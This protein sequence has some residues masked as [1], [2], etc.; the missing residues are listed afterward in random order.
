MT[1][2]MGAGLP[3][4][5]DERLL[6]GRGR[7]LDDLNPAGCLHA[8]F[9]RSPHAKARIRSLDVGPARRDEGVFAF[10]A[11]DLGPLAKPLP[12][13]FPHPSLIAPRLPLPLAKEFV[14][15]VGEPVAVVVAAD[16]Y[17]AEDAAERVRVAYEPLPAVADLEAARRGAARVHEDVADNVAA[18]GERAY[19]DLAAAFRAARH[20]VHM[21]LRIDRGTAASLE[22]RGVL[23]LPTPDGGL[24]V[25]D[26]TQAPQPT[27]QGLARFLELPEEAVR[28]RVPD[29]GGG[30][31]PKSALFYPEEVLVPYLARLL[32][33]P[34]KWVEDR[35]ENFVATNQEREQ[36]HVVR[37]AFDAEGHILGLE[38]EFWHDGGAYAQAGAIL[39]I[40]TAT[41]LMGPYRIPALRAH[42]RVLYTNRTPVSPLRGAGRPQAVFVMERVLA[43]AAADLGLDLQ[44]VRR[45]NFIRP[46]EMPYAV[47]MRYQDE[48][49]L[50]YDSG[51]YEALFDEALAAL[52]YDAWRQEQ[53]RAR[54][55]GRCIGIGVAPYVE[56]SGLGPYE[57]ATLRVDAT[58]AITVQA[59]VASQGQG[60]ETMLALVAG[61][62]LGVDP[63][64]IS[65]RLGDAA[66]FPFGMGTYGSRT[67]V[68]AGSACERAARAL[69]Q[70]ALRYGAALLGRSEEELDLDDA[71]VFC[72]SEPERRVD[73][74][75]LAAE[76][77][78]TWGPLS[79]DFT[80]GLSATAFFVPERATF[81]AGVH[82]AAVEVDPETCR[83]RILRYVVVH[84]AGNLIAPPLVE[85]QIRGGVAHGIGT[86]LYER[87]VFDEGG[88]PLAT[89]FMDYL[90]PTATEVPR[91]EVHHHP[92]PSPLNPLGAKGVGEAGVIPVPACLAEAIEDA[93][94]PFGVRIEAM[95]LSADDL[96]RILYV[97]TTQDG[98][99]V[100]GEGEL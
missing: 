78:P 85:G 46:E 6:L 77:E 2:G 61:R 72:R 30:F 75:R 31:G 5:E 99:E 17:L 40:I 7:F 80:P 87:L 88:Q 95:S 68:T 18:D 83:V 53:A 34:V 1:A 59:G 43:R 66:A 55:D 41:T 9:V 37:A 60:Q 92:V 81:A 63:G 54:R 19:G 27:R 8:V 25:W 49:P 13:V 96:H 33:R 52:G 89:T 47:A 48:A 74:A 20:V 62:T 16:R 76:A 38:D 65:V 32:G 100:N 26:T 42:Y 91:V 50:I 21:T 23:A 56:G 29:V 79:A 64:R 10:S 90:L 93:L 24:D 82:A 84:D 36:I 97:G 86:S 11:A 12:L 70:K 58:G 67:A 39:P 98:R 35:R 71:G 15:Y 69:R 44:S 57:G 14:H 22:T 73:W 51:E 94:G 28:L 3:R 45:R 4:R